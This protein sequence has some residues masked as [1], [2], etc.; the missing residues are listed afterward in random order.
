MPNQR[1]IPRKDNE[2][3][4]FMNRVI[5]YL[6]E[7][8]LRL[9]VR[10][11]SVAALIIALTKWNDLYSRAKNVSTRTM[12]LTANKN[13]MRVEMGALLKTAYADIR[14]PD[15][16]IADENTLNIKAKR[17]KRTLR[18]A[19]IAAPWLIVKILPSARFGIICRVPSDSN[20]PSRHPAADGVELRYFIGEKAPTSLDEYNHT[21]VF[22]RARHTLQVSMNEAS[23]RIHCIARWANFSDH[24]KTGP[25]SNTASAIIVN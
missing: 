10:S 15:L 24:S 16:T 1:I 18:P 13:A 17:A 20:R 3:N 12:T 25:W 22:T 14:K 19:I 21:I 5:P 23:N 6:Q 8:K 4:S 9:N 2:F 7:H 11:E